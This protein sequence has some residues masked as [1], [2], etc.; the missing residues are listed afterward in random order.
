MLE[1]PA[2]RFWLSWLALSAGVAACFSVGSFVPTFVS[3]YGVGF[4]RSLAPVLPVATEWFLAHQSYFSVLPRLLGTVGLLA[5]VVIARRSTRDVSGHWIAL[6]G[7]F[8]CYAAVMLLM[9]F[10]LLFFILPHVRAG[11]Q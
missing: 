10:V 2:I 8:L 1:A 6:I 9:M 3:E 7:A 5:A 4:P 11:L